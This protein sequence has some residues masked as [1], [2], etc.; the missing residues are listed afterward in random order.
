MQQQQEAKRSAEGAPTVA[1]KSKLIREIQEKDRQLHELLRQAMHLR[2]ERHARNEECHRRAAMLEAKI[3]SAHLLPVAGGGNEP[4]QERPS[5][6]LME[7][8]YGAA[9]REEQRL[10]AEELARVEQEKMKVVEVDDELQAKYGEG[11]KVVDVRRIEGPEAWHMMA[12]IEAEKKR[13]EMRQES[14]A[15]LKRERARYQNIPMGRG[16]IM[17]TNSI[18]T[19]SEVVPVGQFAWDGYLRNVYPLTRPE[20][21]IDDLNPFDHP[22]RAYDRKEHYELPVNYF[23]SRCFPPAMRAAYPENDSNGRY[24][25]ERWLLLDR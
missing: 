7:A 20:V 23:Q 11:A 2:R 8:S 6:Q 14:E 5:A 16:Y 1:A 18:M 13:N 15:R 24:V 12:K 9:L 19:G 21:S 17:D 22:T 10:H 3:C 25:D 4:A